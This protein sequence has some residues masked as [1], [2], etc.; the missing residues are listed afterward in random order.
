MLAHIVH[1]DALDEDAMEEVL[2][3]A[4]SLT[5]EPCGLQH[6]GLLFVVAQTRLVPHIATCAAQLT[7]AGPA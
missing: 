4:E 6:H 7:H 1:S 3:F 2:W 5:A